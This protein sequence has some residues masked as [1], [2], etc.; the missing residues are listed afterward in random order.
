[1]KKISMKLLTFKRGKKGHDVS[2]EKR[3]KNIMNEE[4]EK[5]Y[6]IKGDK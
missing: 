4:F 2:L 5:T 1:M 3:M 6:T